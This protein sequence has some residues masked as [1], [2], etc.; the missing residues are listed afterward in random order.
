M[1][2]PPSSVLAARHARVRRAVDALTLDALVVTNPVN[3]RYLANHTGTA[4]T[5]VVTGEAMHLLIDF[6]YEES[7]RQLQASVAACPTLRVWPVPASY[8]EALLACL[9]D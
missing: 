8:D 7:V 5:L 4:G 1:P 2:L 3:I 9:A 6:R